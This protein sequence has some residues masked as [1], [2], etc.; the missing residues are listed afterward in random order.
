MTNT[1][2]QIPDTA[3]TTDE[4]L[5]LQAH[6]AVIERGLKTFYEVGSALLDIRDTRLYRQDYGTFEDY[7]Q[8]RWQMTRRNA[9][10]LIQASEVA[11][12]LSTIVD[13]GNG[14]PGSQTWL[15]ENERQ[16]RPLASLTPDEQRLVADVLQQ[17]APQGKVTA[18]HVK[19]VVTV[20]R[21][22][23]ATGAIDDGSGVQIPIAQA[24]VTHIKAAVLEETSER[25]ARQETHI[26]EKDRRKEQKK[27]QAAFQRDEALK[28]ATKLPPTDRVVLLEGDVADLLRTLHDGSADIVVTDPPYPKDYLWLYGVL[29]EQAARVVK[30]GGLV[31]AMCGQSYLPEVLALMTPHLTYRWMVAYL[32]PGGQSAQLWQRRVNTFWK[33]VLIFT[34][35]ETDGD[36]IGDVVKSAV[37]DNDKRFH[38]WGQSESGFAD[39]MSRFVKPGDVV[40]D[41]F[42]GAGT[43]GAIALS[44]G[45]RFV[46]IDIDPTHIATSR[47]RLAACIAKMA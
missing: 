9:N 28:S 36:W 12:N 24:T 4:C 2:Y 40:L 47:E 45:C 43:T 30:P 7:C 33:P 23:T 18:A 13:T 31:L 21:E 35:G 44:M 15:P 29:A 32:T 27:K 19:S 42:C 17:T 8:Q 5:Q 11:A 34:N 37:N 46:G 22:V 39:L 3:L 20:L 38:E 26:A 10:H 25:M 16:A 41:P 1:L 14:N 6:E